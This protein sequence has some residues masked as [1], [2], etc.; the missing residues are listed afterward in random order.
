MNIHNKVVIITGAS[1]GIG[2]AAAKLLAGKG[3]KIVLA[4]RS[5][6]S[7]EKCAAELPDA[8]AITT[9]M[10]DMNAIENMIEKTQEKYGRIDVLINNAGQGIY[11]AIEN[12]DVEKYRQIFELNVVGPL[13]AMQHVIPIMKKQGGGSI[14][15]ISSM[16]SKAAYPH[17]GAYA[18]TKYAL[19][20][21]S[22]TARTE[23]AAS[24]IIV[25]LVHPTLTLTDFGKNAVKTDAVAEGMQSRNRPNM[26]TADTAEY[27]A[28][29]ILLTIETGRAEMY[30]HDEMEVK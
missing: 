26:P 12:V 4:A 9:D 24:N 6:E 23:L 13:Y 17:L 1:M 11:G 20:A 27:I 21:I 28:E 15:N 25:S 10:T 7:I 3:A 19:N 14:I 22:L 8:F 18:S 29:R 30:A 2:L 5:Q 16:V